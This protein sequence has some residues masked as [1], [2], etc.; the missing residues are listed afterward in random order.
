MMQD[1]GS[2][3]IDFRL[4]RLPYEMLTIQGQKNQFLNAEEL[5]VKKS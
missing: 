2:D 4:K 3:D 1:T 5:F